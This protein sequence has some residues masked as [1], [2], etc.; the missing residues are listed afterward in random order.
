MPSTATPG[1]SPATTSSSGCGRSSNRHSTSRA[2][3]TPTS[4]TPGAPPKPTKSSAATPASNP[5]A[6]PLTGAGPRSADRHVAEEEGAGTA[7]LSGLLEGGVGTQ[8]GGGQE[9]E[10]GRRREQAVAVG[11]VHHV[12]RAVGGAQQE[13]VLDRGPRVSRIGIPV[14]HEVT[15][16]PAVR[17]VAAAVVGRREPRLPRVVGDDQDDA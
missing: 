6:P 11:L 5:P 9:A 8:A 1:A 16:A 4:A 15:G 12:D 7:V 3:S 10:P 2:R 13:R 14:P 17:C